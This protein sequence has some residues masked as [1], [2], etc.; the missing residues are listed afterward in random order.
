MFFRDGTQ[1]P[2]ETRWLFRYTSENFHQEASV[3]G[4]VGVIDGD[5]RS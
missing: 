5:K 4:S 2:L 1:I 3:D